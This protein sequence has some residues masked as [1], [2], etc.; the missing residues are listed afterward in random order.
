MQRIQGAPKAGLLDQLRGELAAAIC[1][2]V[3]IVPD[4]VQVKMN[5]HQQ[6]LTLAIEIEIPA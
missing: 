4:K 1:R 3:A 6:V 5:R 2:H